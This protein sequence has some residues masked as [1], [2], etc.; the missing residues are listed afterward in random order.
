M[1]NFYVILDYENS[2]FALS[3]NFISVSD[4]PDKHP[5]ANAE[6]GLWT[7]VAIVVGI[8]VLIAIVGFCVVRQKNRRLQSNLSKY[9]QL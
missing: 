2:Q 3:G 1:E 8:L 6:N 4:T 5:G 7:I 9:E